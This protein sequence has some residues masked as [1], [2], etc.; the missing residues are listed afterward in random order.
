MAEIII[1]PKL[2]FNMSEGKLIKWYKKEGESVAK[3]ENLFSIE[4]D[5]TSIDIE[6]TRDGVI[7][8]ILVDEGETV[9]VTLPIA[10]IGTSDES[11][12]AIEGKALSD[13]GGSYNKEDKT[14]A[15]TRDEKN[16]QGMKLEEGP[17]NDYDLIV[18][19]GG[20]GGYVAAI[21]AAQIGKKVAIVE[22]EALGGTCLNVGC[23]P[24]KALMRSIQS[25]NEVK[26]SASFG[27]ANVDIASASLDLSVVQRRKAQIVKE[28]VGGV[29]GL[30]KGN[31][32]SIYSGEG[33]MVNGNTV[34][35]NK[36]QI[37][38]DY[39]IIATGSSVKELP[40]PKSSEMPLLTSKEMLD[41]QEIPK[42]IAVI[43]GGVIGV[44]F[45]YFLAS[46]GAKVTILEFLDKVLPMVDSEI[47]SKVTSDIEKL[48]VTIKTSAKVTEITKSGVKY[49]ADG[50]VMEVEVD[51]V[52]MAVGRIPRLDGVDCVKLGIKQ[53]R[54]AIYTDEYLRTSLSN[55]Y[56]IGDV[57][58]KIMLAHTASME[59]IIAVENIFGEPKKMSYKAIPSAIFIYPE[60][61]TVGLTEEQAREKYNAIRVGKFPILANGK[62]KV[63]GEERGMIKVISEDKYGEILGVHMYCVHATDMI[64]EISLAMNLEATA[65][66]VALSVHPHPTLSEAIQEAMHATVDRPIHFI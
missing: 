44:E 25:L 2:G 32:V 39:I 46:A 34:E 33:T 27:V 3:G 58:G 7:R 43:G 51:Q 4:T 40:I 23:I 21:K 65:E 62:A 63:E 15:T 13:L 11:I 41:L 30:L 9:L 66:E 22:K 45:A 18:L 53:E 61:A 5:K 14:T 36:E 31:G 20:P 12:E 1:M 37:T 54:G 56:A 8:R 24:T 49:E 10:I 35:V 26:D 6:A 60:I 29:S 59:G 50:Q 57:N 38:A 48:G 47:T 64:S 19:G 42:S 16:P 55:V 52:L 28:L 17:G